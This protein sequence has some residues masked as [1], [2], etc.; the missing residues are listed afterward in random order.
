LLFEEGL[1]G[2]LGEAGGG[3]EGELLHGVEID[4]EAGPVL[5]EGAS[6]HDLAPPGG[7]AAEFVEFLGG[8]GAPRHD[9]SCLGVETRS[10]GQGALIKVRR[11]T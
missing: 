7:Q 10:K 1:E 5:A 4:V 8:E 3:G 2:A 6:G 9:A 11:R